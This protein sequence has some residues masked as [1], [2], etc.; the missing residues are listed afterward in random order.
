MSILLI[1]IKSFASEAITISVKSTEK[2]GDIMINVKSDKDIIKVKMYIENK[3]GKYRLFFEDNNVKEKEKTYRISHFRLNA[4]KETK[5]KIVAIDIDDKEVGKEILGPKLPNVPVTI[6]TPEPTTSSTPSQT[7]QPSRP[8]PSPSPTIPPE[9]TN[10]TIKLDKDVQMLDVNHYKFTI[11]EATTTPKNSKIKWTS[12]NE[13]VVKISNTTKNKAKVTATGYGTAKVTA[14][15]NLNG[16][17]ATAKC[18]FRVI[19]TM[20]E[21]TPDSGKYLN[22]K[23][24]KPPVAYYIRG[25]KNKNSRSKSWSKA[26]VESYINNAAWLLKMYPDKFTE[27]GARKYYYYINGRERVINKKKGEIALKNNAII[28]FSSK[29]QWLYLLKRNSKGKWVIDE[30][31]RSS[32][33]YYWGGFDKYIGR[34]GYDYG[35]TTFSMYKYAGERGTSINRN[36]LHLSNLIPG[37]PTSGGCIHLGNSSSK[38]YKKIK[39]LGPGTRI[40]YY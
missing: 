30:A 5:F 20:K 23:E 32:G 25:Y 3:E 9:I 18:N 33:G 8:L 10:V 4:E 24:K 2:N 19:T 6:A 21:K 22:Y 35:G 29:N 14:T 16:K 7:T 11:L 37:Y 40:I 27:G 13:K 39:A 1:S 31:M 38:M 17:T 34:T 36:A 12:S 28:F 26:E 15:I